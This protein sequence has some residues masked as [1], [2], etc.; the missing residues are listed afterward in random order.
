MDK[1]QTGRLGSK[2]S[3]SRGVQAADQPDF[4]LQSSEIAVLRQSLAAARS[5]MRVAKLD[6]EA[7]K[8]AQQ[9]AEKKLRRAQNRIDDPDALLVRQIAARAASKA[10][11]SHSGGGQTP[12][13]PLAPKIAKDAGSGPSKIRRSERSLQLASSRPIHHTTSIEEPDLF[14]LRI[15]APRGK[16]AVV[17][18]LADP[19]L[20][21]V[22]CRNLANIPEAFDLFVTLLKGYRRR[23]CRA[24]SRKLP[25]GSSTRV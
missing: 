23:C 10:V 18:H 3:G 16:V 5:E 13:R 24:D 12:L 1:A 4:T 8:R 20:W 6:A 17:V 2:P 15:M 11:Q 25:G 14:A 9:E 22:L 7:A 21:P 19:A